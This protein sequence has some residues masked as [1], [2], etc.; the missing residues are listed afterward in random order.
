MAWMAMVSTS[1]VMPCWPQKSSISWVSLIPPMREP[2]TD[3]RP[4][5]RGTVFSMG[6]RS[7]R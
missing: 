4:M 7:P 5:M 2:A 6:L 3:L 1:A